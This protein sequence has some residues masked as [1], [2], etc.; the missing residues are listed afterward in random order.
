MLAMAPD[1]QTAQFLIEEYGDQIN[2]L[3]VSLGLGL[4]RVE[5]TVKASSNGHAPVAVVHNSENQGE[6]ESPITLNPKF[7]FESF[8][9]GSCNQFAHAAA[10]S[11]AMNPSRAYNPLFI[12]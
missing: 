12:Y 5:F 9:V 1:R 6:L 10:Q 7:T 3:A 11:V 8:V 2:Q 4:E